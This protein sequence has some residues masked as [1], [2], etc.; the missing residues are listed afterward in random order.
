MRFVTALIFALFP[1]SAFAVDVPVTNYMLDNGMEVV[2]V[3][4]RRAPVI[5]HMV[6][7]KVG[8]ADEPPGK[9]GIAHYLEHLMFK[10]TTTRDVGEFSDIVAA[11]G[12]SENAFTSFDYTG[13]FQRLASDRLELV[14]ELEADRMVNLDIPASE[15]EP[16]LGVVL[17][18]RNQRT[19]SN[20]GSLLTEQRRAVEFINHPYGR[21]IIGW[22]SEIEALTPQDVMDFYKA[23]YAPNNAI[24]VVAGDVDP[25]EV[26]RLAEIYYGVIPA[27]PEIKDRVRPAEPPRLAAARLS[28]EDPRFTQPYLIRSYPA[29]VRESGDQRAAAAATMLAQVLGGSGV[30][31]VLGKSLVLEQDIALAASS[32]HWDQSYD[33]QTLAFYAAPKAGVSLE[34]MEAALDAA[35]LNFME[36]GVDPEQ[37]D[38]I[39]AQIR[40]SLVYALD[41]QNGLARSFGE[42]LTQDLTV[43]DVLAWPEILQSITED[44]IMAAARDI[45]DP[46]KSTTSYALQPETN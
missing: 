39:K 14:M 13:Y 45:F 17:A 44:E 3:E 27:N 32:W 26:L 18:E 21:P 34:D 7:Y 2:V 9:S 15:F 41:S 31:S 42:A 43:E 4:D 40:A 1:V 29:P 37:L 28:Y 38:R 16:E 22:R 10:G 25:E 19:D 8:S 11:N 5:T 6:W 24:L 20:P 35:I 23:H 12:G 33:P 30:T 46:S 36:T